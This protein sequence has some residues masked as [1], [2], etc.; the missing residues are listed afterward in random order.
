MNEQQLN[1]IINNS[2]K[3][4]GFSHKIADPVGGM[5]VENPFD[6]F[7]ILPGKPVYWESKLLK[8]YKAFNF[9]LI[10]Q[11]QYDN[12]IV[13]KN[14]LPDSYCLIFVGVFVPYKYFDLYAFDIEFI[15]YLR[16]EKH[17]KSILKKE[18][19]EYKRINRYAEIKKDK[20]GKNRKYFS[21]LII[22]GR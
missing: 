22:V 13:I 4:I 12:L 2:F 6:G 10:K 11:H 20:N 15:K 3:K 7:S 1:T 19:Y 16:E 5:G 9:Q 17:K 14:L 21:Q 8:G 18:L